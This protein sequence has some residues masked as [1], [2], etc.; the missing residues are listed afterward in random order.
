MNGD[1]HL[2]QLTEGDIQLLCSARSFERGQELYWREAIRHPL[3]QGSTLQALCEGSQAEPY[4][5]MA[6]LDEQGVA[7][8]ECSCPYD[9]GGHCKHIVALLLTWVHDPQE[10][11]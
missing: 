9:W 8:A 4:R 5:V 7:W 3:R 6:E 1:E 10:F 2:P 11:A